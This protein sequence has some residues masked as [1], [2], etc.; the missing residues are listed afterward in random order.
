MAVSVVCMMLVLFEI[1]CGIDLRENLYII[2]FLIG[3]GAAVFAGNVIYDR[4]KYP[5]NRKSST[6]P[7][8]VLI[9]VTGVMADVIA[10]YV[11]DTSSGLLFSLL[12][13]LLYIIYT[14]VRM[15]FQYVRQEKQFAEQKM[16]LAENER[17]LAEKE[18]K[19][20]Q[21]L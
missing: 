3:F 21:T 9:L 8:A 4:I 16:I 15:V 13:M 18:Q 10:F 12:G 14:G 17:Q 11:R 20:R 7:K 5:Q 19:E 1:V 2:H 6:S